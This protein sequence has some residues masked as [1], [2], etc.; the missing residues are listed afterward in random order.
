MMCDKKHAYQT[1]L[2]ETPE[3]Y[4]IHKEKFVRA[5]GYLTCEVVGLLRMSMDLGQRRP[6]LV[7]M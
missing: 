1:C 4:H 2:N 3:D 5:K 7:M 6:E